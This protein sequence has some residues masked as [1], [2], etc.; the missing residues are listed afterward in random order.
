MSYADQAAAAV[1]GLGAFHVTVGKP[2]LGL[3]MGVAGYM[4][5]GLDGKLGIQVG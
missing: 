5:S 3:S 2:L 4:I 1:M